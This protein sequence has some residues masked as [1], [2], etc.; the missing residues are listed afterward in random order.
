MSRLG[1]ADAP[2]GWFPTPQSVDMIVAGD[3][4]A[5][6]KLSLSGVM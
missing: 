1:A 2:A 5:S 3:G 6:V 4:V